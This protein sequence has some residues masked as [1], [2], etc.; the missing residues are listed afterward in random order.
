MI[1]HI[2]MWNFK[3]EYEGMKK[4]EIMEK[5]KSG[6]SALKGK[7]PVVRDLEVGQSV[8]SGDMHYDMALIVTVDS[9]NDLPAY[10]E[11][12]EHVKVR[13]FI[14]EVRTARVTADIEV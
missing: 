3:D 2:V 4:P 12:P 5:V 7:V 11:H 14:G 10:A 1:R 13:R 9:V 8:T 6:L